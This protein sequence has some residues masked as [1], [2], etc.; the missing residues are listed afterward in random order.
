MQSFTSRLFGPNSSMSA[1]F[2]PLQPLDRSAWR[3]IYGLLDVYYGQ[4][5]L[6]DQLRKAVYASALGNDYPVAL[7]NPVHRV[8]ECYPARL[9]PG[10]LP[11]ALPIIS[12][13]DKLPD[14]INTIWQWSNWNAQKQVAAR[15]LPLYGEIYIKVVQTEDKSRVFF[16][17]IRPHYVSMVDLDERGVITYLRIDVPQIEITN[18]LPRHVYHTEVWSEDSYRKWIHDKPDAKVEE[19]GIPEQEF[20]LKAFGIDF[21]PIVRIPFIDAGDARGH[22]A[23]T[24]ALDKIDEA[25]RMATNL[26][27]M[28]FRHADGIWAAESNATDKDGRPLAPPRIGK[29]ATKGD[30]SSDTVMIGND[31]ILRLPSTWTLKSLVPLVPYKEA[32]DILQDMMLELEADMPEMAFYRV[33]HIQIRGALSG[34]A[35]EMMLQDAVVRIE[36]ARGNAEAGL[37]RAN[38][39]AITIAQAAGL[40]DFTGLGTYESGALDHT[41]KARNVIRTSDAEEL[42]VIAQL[43]ATFSEMEKLRRL[44]YSDDAITQIMAE[45]SSDSAQETALAESADVSEKT[46]MEA[47]VLKMQAGVPKRQLWREM[48]YTDQ[49]IAQMEQDSKDEQATTANVGDAMLTAFNRGK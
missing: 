14:A 49:Q 39:M 40:S 48:G 27:R 34:R 9:W 41:F 32:L 17:L 24:H 22:G 31:S 30:K 2:R 13:N 46:Q 21:I 47:L 6:Y 19:L 43:P 28:L 18:D 12:D 29:E 20:E 4:N 45:R 1:S 35:I 38:Q 25:N 8:V 10:T 36:E 15:W 33:R 16:Q 7:R 44:G 3:E 23:V 42:E 37:I 5:A 11:H 26:H